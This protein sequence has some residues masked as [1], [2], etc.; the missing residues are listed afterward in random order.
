MVKNHTI[1]SE[2]KN[3][4]KQIILEIAKKQAPETAKQLIILVQEKTSLS[5]EEIAKLL[6]ELENEDK[7]HFLKKAIHLPSTPQAYVFS[8]KSMWYWLTLLLSVV[9]ALAII[10]IPQD[11][12]P[13]L[14]FRSALALVFSLFIPGFVFMKVIFPSGIPVKK[15]G[16]VMDAIARI[17][18]SF[19]VSLALL[20]IVG[21]LL[22]YTVLGITL[23]PITLSLLALVVILAT[24]AIMR[25]YQ[26][27]ASSV[28]E[29]LQLQTVAP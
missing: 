15:N 4:I 26:L 6:I 27:K 1:S 18:L 24:A 22:N 25:E 17:A 21:L 10:L 9:T 16:E 13:I 2:T 8:K 12:Y 11:S 19:G 23:A 28:K 3:Q 29:C 14:Y 7:L 20:S 5:Y